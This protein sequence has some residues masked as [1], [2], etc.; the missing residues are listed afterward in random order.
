MSRWL[1][2]YGLPSLFH[3]LKALPDQSE[4]NNLSCFSKCRL[5][6]GKPLKKNCVGF[7]FVFVFVFKEITVKP[8]I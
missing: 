1:Q 8:K 7:F 5:L 6:Q 2:T 4:K 3:C